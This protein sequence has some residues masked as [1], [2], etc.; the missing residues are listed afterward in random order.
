MLVS[1]A[2]MSYVYGWDEAINGPLTSISP[3][4]ATIGLRVHDSNH[5]K[6][7]GIQTAVRLVAT[8][9]H[10]GFIHS[11]DPTAPPVLVEEATSGFAVCNLRGYYN[12][13]RNLS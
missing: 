3:L 11:L 2:L 7:W 1:G 13:S 12:Y 9:D 10:P 5:G 4:E 6:V 8:Q